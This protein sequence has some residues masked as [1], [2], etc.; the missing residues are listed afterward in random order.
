VDIVR[1]EVIDLVAFYFFSLQGFELPHGFVFD[2]R[3]DLRF[4]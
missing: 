1:V 2:D 3:E 4:L